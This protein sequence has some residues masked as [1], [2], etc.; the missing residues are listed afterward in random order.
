MPA[1]KPLRQND[2]LKGIEPM[3]A[4]HEIADPTALLSVI[5]DVK[6][7][8]I[9]LSILLH[10]GEVVSALGPCEQAARGKML[11]Y[12]MESI[13]HIEFVE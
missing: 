2:L 10:S 13:K 1:Q 7:G 8:Q 4:A 12:G 9:L 3:S 11:G 5:A 6:Q